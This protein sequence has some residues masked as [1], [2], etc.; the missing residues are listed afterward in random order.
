[1]GA[2]AWQGDGSARDILTFYRD[3]L[4][5]KGFDIRSQQRSREGGA[6]ANSLWARNEGTGRV[7]FLVA[8]EE[9]GATKALLGYGEKK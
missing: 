8:G 2:V 9:D 3:W 7:V 4:E 5:G 1:M 6:E